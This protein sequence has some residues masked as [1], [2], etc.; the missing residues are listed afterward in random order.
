MT[1]AC[2]C[3]YLS[4]A[5]PHA[6]QWPSHPPS[7]AP[8]LLLSPSL[9]HAH[10]WPSPH[11]SHGKRNAHGK[12]QTGSVQG[13]IHSPACLLH[14][15][16]LV[17]SVQ[18]ALLPDVV[19]E[20]L[21]PGEL[22]FN[23]CTVRVCACVYQQPFTCRHPISMQAGRQAQV[24]STIMQR[25]PKC[26]RVRKRRSFPEARALILFCNSMLVFASRLPAAHPHATHPSHPPSHAH[27]RW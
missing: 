18:S 8:A 2:A 15:T 17:T 10:P 25:D 3:F 14:Q 26:N 6:P 7:P 27:P 22:C 16:S 5:H 24:R 21:L 13:T 9:A 11:P 19:K 12:R 4:A 1:C 23:I 20:K